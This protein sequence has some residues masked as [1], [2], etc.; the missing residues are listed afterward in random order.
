MPLIFVAAAVAVMP[1]LGITSLN[2]FWQIA[3]TKIWTGIP[4]EG[5]THY[6]VW[7]IIFFAWLCNS[8]MHIGLADMS[9]Y[10]YAK[11]L[12]MGWLRQLECTSGMEWRGWLRAYCVRWH[13]RTATP[14][15]RLDR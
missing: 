14:I 12:L 4:I 7:H 9:I 2:D 3:N 10:R 6:T 8:A 1:Q 11:N 15:L 13:C 5:Q